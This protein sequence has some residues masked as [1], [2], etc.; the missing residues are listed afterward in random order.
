MPFV[1]LTAL[2]DRNSELKGRKLG[3]ERHQAH[4]FRRASGGSAQVNLERVTVNGNAFGIAADGS[5]STGGINMTIA[6]NIRSWQILLQRSFCIPTSG[7]FF[8]QP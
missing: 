4:R 3:A 7:C 5:N 1:F 2:T 8:T 6:E